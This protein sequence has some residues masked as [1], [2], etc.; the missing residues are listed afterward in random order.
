MVSQIYF[1]PKDAIFSDKKLHK[2][3]VHFSKKVTYSSGLGKCN[4]PAK[5][6]PARRFV[7][8]CFLLSF[9]LCQKGCVGDLF[10]L[11]FGFSILEI[12]DKKTFLCYY[13]CI[14]LRLLGVL[15]LFGVPRSIVFPKRIRLRSVLFACRLMTNACV[16]PVVIHLREFLLW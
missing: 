10:L 12:V 6:G 13:N 1:L 7:S 14:K 8:V 9:L 16:P 3:D 2:K 15:R 4:L 5:K 11:G